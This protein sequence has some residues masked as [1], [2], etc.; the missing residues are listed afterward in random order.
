MTVASSDNRRRRVA[1]FAVAPLVLPHEFAHALVAW[2]VGLDPT[3][4]LLPR[5]D[6]PSVPLG[7]FDADIDADTPTWVIRAIA[8]APTPLALGFA[9]IFRVT[10]AFEGVLVVPLILALGYTGSLSGGDIAV[11]ANPTAAQD[12]GRF[13]VPPTRWQALSVVGA[14]A[15]TLTV[16]ALLIG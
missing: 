16:A 3:V 1:R 9:A 12:A 14:P 7:R 2:L 13:I 4:E 8:F 6:G 11:I 15:T 5:W 10:S